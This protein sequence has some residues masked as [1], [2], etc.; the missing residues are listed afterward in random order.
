M[1]VLANNRSAKPNQYLALS[2]PVPFP[3]A[4]GPCCDNLD[5]LIPRPLFYSLYDVSAS[6]Q[7]FVVRRRAMFGNLVSAMDSL[8]DV[9]VAM[10]DEFCD[11]H[12]VR[13]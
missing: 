12:S 6:F 4:E 8:D 13:K 3:P 10:V 1:N 11:R 7:S 5:D 9:I 2:L